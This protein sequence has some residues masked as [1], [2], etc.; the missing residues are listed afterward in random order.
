MMK[1]LFAIVAALAVILSIS[2]MT[3][4]NW[5]RKRDDVVVTHNGQSVS[6]VNVYRSRDGSLLVHLERGENMYVIRP[7]NREIG[8]PNRSSF[9][10]LPGYA[11]SRNA[12]PLLA[13]MGKAEI[14]PQLVIDR[15]SIEF[16][17]VDSGR[18]RV[19]WQ[20]GK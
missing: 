5:W 7:E 11:F 13:S 12:P 14:D 4:S 19:N 10:I 9:F 18:V 15:E 6:N 17:S 16:S 3:A 2:I 8:I 1:V 20:R